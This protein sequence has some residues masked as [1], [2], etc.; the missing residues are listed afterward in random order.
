[1]LGGGKAHA[2]AGENEGGGKCKTNLGHWILIQRPTIKMLHVLPKH[3][4]A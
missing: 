4:R 3:G 1:M 2:H